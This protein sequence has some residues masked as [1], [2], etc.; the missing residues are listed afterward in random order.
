MAPVLESSFVSSAESWASPITTLGARVGN[1]TFATSIT[2]STK[3]SSD[4]AYTGNVERSEYD[5][6]VGR[7]I[8]DNV[9]AVLIYKGAKLKNS[10]T[11]SA[12]SAIQSA[13]TQDISA[14][15]VG[16]RGNTSI[17]N[18]TTMY[19]N[20]AIGP[21]RLKTKTTSVVQPL[22]NDI[23]NDLLYAIGEVGV[24][25]QLQGDLLGR[26][27]L[28]LGYRFQSVLTKQA[29]SYTFELPAPRIRCRP[30]NATSSQRRK[31]SF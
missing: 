26:M 19:G 28:Q 3:A 2:P 25:H 12:A 10:L 17:A 6:N 23:K 21:G 11:I 9:S 27:S 13:V 29:K 30:A 22:S 14:F 8:S 18:R 7:S 15:L 16:L 31:G 20:L 5:I 1:W 24:S 4:L